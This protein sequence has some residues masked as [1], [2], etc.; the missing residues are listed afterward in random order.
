MELLFNFDTLIYLYLALTAA[1][2]IYPLELMFRVNFINFL[3]MALLT[4]IIL[5]FKADLAQYMQIFNFFS[6]DNKEFLIWNMGI[7]AVWIIYWRITGEISL[8]DSLFTG[9]LPFIAVFYAFTLLLEV[10]FPGNNI[11]INSI[12]FYIAY[13]VFIYEKIQ[14]QAFFSVKSMGDR[15]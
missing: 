2:I 15:F 1:T 5:V 11:L 9:L 8:I 7:A 4:S 10:A 14:I 13:G 6:L 3:F 12:L